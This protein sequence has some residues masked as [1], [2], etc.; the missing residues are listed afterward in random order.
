MR[1]GNREPRT[2]MRNR[3]PLPHSG[4]RFPVPC[5]H[6]TVAVAIAIAVAASACGD[7]SGSSSTGPARIGP[8]GAARQRAPRRLSTARPRGVP[9]GGQIDQLV[10]TQDGTAALTRDNTGGVRLWARLDGTAQPVPIPIR[11]PAQMSLARAGDKLTAAMIDS[12]GGTHFL[13]LGERGDTTELSSL[14]PGHASEVALLPGGKGALVLHVDRSIEL[15]D[16]ATGMLV[17]RAARR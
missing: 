3:K 12:A 13:R 17:A 16:T 10:L 1:T 2:G 9:H 15:V 4:S 8:G 14:P 5:S 6:P 7:R 11:A